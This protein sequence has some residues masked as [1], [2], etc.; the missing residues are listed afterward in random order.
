MLHYHVPNIMPTNM[1][2][3]YLYDSTHYGFDDI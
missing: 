3:H 2:Q 1:Q